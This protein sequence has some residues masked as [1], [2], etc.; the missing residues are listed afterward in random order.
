LEEPHY[1]LEHNHTDQNV[2]NESQHFCWSNFITFKD[3][4][5]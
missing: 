5:N 3:D 4:H 1:K 2:Q